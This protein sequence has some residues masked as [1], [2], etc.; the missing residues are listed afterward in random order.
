MVRMLSA[1]VLAVFVGQST[2]AFAF[3]CLGGG[4]GEPCREE[5]CGDEGDA[6]GDEGDA[7]G[8]EGDAHG[9][10]A[11][12]R[13]GDDGHEHGDEGHERCP[14]P[15]DCGASCAGSALRAVAP[16]ALGMVIASPLAGAMV[17]WCED[18]GPPVLDPGEILHVPRA[19]G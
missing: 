6:H 12:A 17:W 16:A 2:L 1:L 19:V 18:Q 9:D 7:H 3:P 13:G 11:G 15:I 14:C 5:P 4:C 8:D 10:E